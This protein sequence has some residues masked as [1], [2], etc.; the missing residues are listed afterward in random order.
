M[1]RKKIEVVELNKEKEK[2]VLE[3][4]SSTLAL[5]FKKNGYYIFMSILL[6]SLVSLIVG[7][8]I[9]FKNLSL[10][11]DGSIANVELN[12][13]ELESS[14]V[15]IYGDMSMTDTGAENHFNRTG[16]FKTSGE[17][18]FIKKVTAGGYTIKYYS[19]GTALK[20]MNDGFTTRINE[21][22]DGSYGITENGVINNQ[23]Q[24]ADVTIIKTKEYN[25]GK[26][27]Y[28][29]DGSA[30]I[31]NADIDIFVRNSNDIKENYISNH[32]LSYQKE[33]KN[34]SGT[35]LY[36]YNDGTI[37]V[38]K[39]NKSYL[40]RN[41]EDIKISET[42]SFPNNNESTITKTKTYADKF[43]IDYY[44]D[45]GAIVRKGSNSFSVRNSNS[46]IIKNNKIYEIVDNIYVEIASK[47]GN[48]TYYTNGGATTE[49]N[50]KQIYVHENSNIKYNNDNTIKNV[51]EDYEEKQKETTIKG[52]T[53]TIFEETA[54][55]KTEDLIAIVPTDNI[56][57]NSDGTFKE[58]VSPNIKDNTNDFSITNNK[59]E[60]VKFRITIEKSDRTT[61]DVNYIKYQLA[62]KDIHIPPTKL[63]KNIWE[64]DRLASKLSA[65]GT[66]YILVEGIIEPYETINVKFMI[67]TDYETIPNTMQ[68]KYFY[69]TIKVYGWTE[70]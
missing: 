12:I 52:T 43:K 67:W 55:V 6:L 23:A 20:I 38:V 1:P 35:K 13:S 64:E 46:I 26:V 53:I 36:Y 59:G 25:W 63:N 29:S 33:T 40:V 60:Q 34:I 66:N 24:K 5:F 42:I 7:L 22:E 70:N 44:S 48:T 28:Y 68:D 57:Y 37:E 47:K 9:F 65:K 19:D 17:A 49:Y 56:I 61:L 41:S 62:L 45:G 18:I 15:D 21:L 14:F 27:T 32:K 4:K 8:F 39:N 2:I 69:G 3:E 10:S 50:G 30:Q 51:T 58:I 31:T 54:I 11:I 16:I